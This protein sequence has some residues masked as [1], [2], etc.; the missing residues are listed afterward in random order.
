[1]IKK[2]I[3]KKQIEK[4][5]IEK[6]QIEKNQTKLKNKIIKECNDNIVRNTLFWLK[7]YFNLF[8]G[9]YYIFLHYLLMICIGFIL[10]FSNNLIYLCSILI[11]ILII[12]IINIMLHNCPLTHLE[13]KYLGKSQVKFIK[14]TIKQMGIHY[15][16]NNIYE[17]QLEVLTNTYSFIM[18]KIMIIIIL[19][20]LNI[21]INHE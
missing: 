12:T 20:M 1:M 9:G 16:S 7:P 6:K 19:K 11:I 17:Y 3:E 21:N 4:K 13:R 18:F 5:Q 14:E 2:Q 8:M 15:R 10:F